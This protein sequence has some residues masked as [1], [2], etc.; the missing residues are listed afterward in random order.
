MPCRPDLAVPVGVLVLGLLPAP[1]W[2]PTVGV[3][4]W[5]QDDDKKADQVRRQASGGTTQASSRR[6]CRIY[7]Y[8]DQDAPP[9]AAPML[10]S[11]WSPRVPAGSIPLAARGLPAVLA[12]AGP[13]GAI[14]HRTTQ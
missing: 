10:L 14:A 7:L 3:I 5:S 6:C 11:P 2:A 1:R 9:A 12:R 8:G 13:A 4:G